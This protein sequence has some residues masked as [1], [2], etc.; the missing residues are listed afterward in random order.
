MI[1]SPSLAHAHLPARRKNWRP[2]ALSAVA[3]C[4]APSLEAEETRRDPLRDRVYFFTGMDVARD[5]AYGWAGMA[6]APFARMDEEGLRL[7][8]QT[9][10]GAYRYRT[11]A[12]PGG[13]NN[14]NKLEG[15]VLAGWQ[16][17]RG[18]HAVAVYAGV[19][20]VDNRLDL[21][22][23]GNKDQGTQ[24]GAKLVVEWFYRHDEFWTF[25]AALAGSTADETASVRAT[26][27]RRIHPWFDL[28]L[29]ASASTDWLSQDARGGLFLATPLP[30]WQWRV[31]GGWRWSSDSDDGAY[32]TLSLY[33]PY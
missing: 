29:E 17:L 19:N 7:R 32:G 11:D 33:A 18:P 20:M 8:T 3:F 9:G 28:G 2:V 1:G 24:F 15:E 21:P 31:A 6:W 30:G 13:W 4:L 12:V 22:D 14:A 23:P 10:G 5:N 16:W 25:T 27:A 26:A